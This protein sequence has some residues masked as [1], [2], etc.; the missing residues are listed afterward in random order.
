[1]SK[2]SACAYLIGV[3]L[4]F[5]GT[6]ANSAAIVTGFAAVVVALFDVADAIRGKP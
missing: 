6:S 5:A 1:M 3:A 4:I 2:R